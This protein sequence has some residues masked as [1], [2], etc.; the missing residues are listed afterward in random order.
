MHTPKL[1]TV[2]LLV[3]IFCTPLTTQIVP[4]PAHDCHCWHQPD[5]HIEAS[6]PSY[7]MVSSE[8]PTVTGN[9]TEFYRR[10]TI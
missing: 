9:F 1:I 8:T 7:P 4:Q 3:T 6:E 10:A 5:R 2:G